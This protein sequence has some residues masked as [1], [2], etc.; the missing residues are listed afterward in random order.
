MNTH[1][2]NG[3]CVVQF[4]FPVPTELA[5]SSAEVIIVG[6]GPTG[7]CAANLLGLAGI[8]TLILE[9]NSELSNY[10]KAISLDDEGLRICQA[11]G[12]R[13]TIEHCIL[14][15]INAHYLCGERLLA[16]VAPTSRR[17]GYPLISTFNQ[18]EFEMTL[19]AGLERFACVTM[20]FQHTVQSIEQTSERVI[21]SV[22]TPDGD[23]RR[24]ECAYLLACDG[25]RSTIRHALHIPMKGSTYGQKWAVIDCVDDDD[26]TAI[27]KFFCN[28]QR[29]AMTVPSP[30]GGR[31]WEFMLLPGEAEQEMLQPERIAALIRGAGGSARPQIIRRAIYTFHSTLAQRFS[32]G[33]VFLLG[34]AAH[35]M[36]P[37]GGQGLNSGLRDAHNLCWKLALVL[38]D[39]AHSRL[40]ETYS[41]ERQRHVAQMIFFSSLLGNVV[42]STRKSVAM[43]RNL[44]LHGLNAIPAMREYLAEAG[45]KPKP[46]YTSGFF[47]CDGSRISRV[48][49]GTMLP[50]PEVTTMQGQRVL[51]DDLLGTDFA[52]VAMRGKFD[53][54]YEV[55]EV[56]STSHSNSMF[57]ER[58]NTRKVSV[59]PAIGQGIGSKIGRN[60]L[61]PYNEGDLFIVLR[62]DRYVLGV[63]REEKAEQFVSAFH[64]LLY[65]DA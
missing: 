39:L 14:S 12:L 35:M 60:S 65:P 24:F 54:T 20:L 8:S 40:L 22:Y 33:R 63:F 28:P 47:L 17:N 53:K 31:R 55:R 49:T 48:M 41:E 13:G 37:F 21:V 46:R 11:M 36:P 29:P 18:P 7:L 57:W 43:G 61:R 26:S 15:G 3:H 25:G 52:I 42:M 50:Q 59:Q 16:K 4:P 56:C 2:G 34:D 5:H 44:L 19:L 62:P 64:R 32:Q 1:I 10:P 45:I 6:G 23:L 51:L 30:H 9:R 27:A 58:L 38:R